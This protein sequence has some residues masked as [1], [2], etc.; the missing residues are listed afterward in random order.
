MKLA[1]GPGDPLYQ[2]GSF[3]ADP[4]VGRLYHRSEE[5]PL[6]P[7]SFSV[8]MVLVRLQGQLVDKEELF[9]QVWPD[10]FVEPNN[11]AR[12]VSMIRKA[13]H[14][15]D[16]DQEYIATVP[17]RGYRLL[18]STCQI[19]RS[20]F[21]D[22]VHPARPDRAF[23]EHALLRPVTWESSD[24][25]IARSTDPTHSGK[26]L[27][28][29]GGRATRRTLS[30]AIS[31]AALVAAA[32]T[33][34]FGSRERPAN[35]MTERRLWQLS[36][37]GR[38]Q[39]DPTW[40]PDGQLIAYSSDRG[41][42]FDIWVQRLS[43]GS[44][45]QMTSG[46][47]RDWQPS[48]SPDGRYIAFRS[49]RDGGSLYV[50]P[51]GGGNE[52]RIADFGYQPQW[53]PDGSR[54][55]F[56]EA[57]D[58]YVVGLDGAAPSRVAEHAL[59]DLIGRF[60]VAWHPDGRR[61][62]VYGNDRNHGWSFWTVPLDG[63]PRARSVVASA[64]AARL[65]D[66]G[67]R[68]GGFIWA[69][70]GDTLYFEGR[71]EQTQNVWRI[72]VNPRTLEWVSGPD[73]LTT[74]SN[75][76]SGLALSPDG[77]QLA[78]GSRVEHTVAWSFPFDPVSGRI[79]G[80][81]E[82]VTPEGANAE[83]LD[84]SPDGNQLV[85][86]VTGRNRHELWIRSLNRQ[87]DFL[88]TVEVEA[89]IVQPRWSRDGTQLAYLRRPADRMH[90][91]SVVLL[92]A[93]DDGEERVLAADHSPE[94]VYDWSVDGTSLLV[95]CRT[96]SVRSAICRMP[97]A[98]SG[99]KPFM[100]LFAADED[101]NLY[102]AKYSPDGRWVSFIAAPDLTRSTVFVSSADGGP[103]IAITEAEDRHFE[104]KPRWS[105]DG[106]ALYF[107]SNRTGFWNVWGRRF[108]PEAARPVGE[109]FQVSRFDSSV[110]MV[111]PNVSNLQIAVTG[112][113]LILPITQTSGNV[114]ILENV[115][116]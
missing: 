60:R 80:P 42:S 32:S 51:A 84:I 31:L 5:V 17:G 37:M 4:V 55:L 65:R 6:T 89:A 72:R 27:P 85:Y 112:T 88:R 56:S 95:R 18:A 87:S 115:D 22:R 92:A 19:S 50:V 47:T 34:V 28:T 45:I 14:E 35:S 70:S 25:G 33:F 46:T 38:Q 109:P 75:L 98:A 103:W 82:A 41:D 108:D 16:C 49:E 53:S 107:L 44:P 69:R 76:E 12:N 102:A 15:R 23:Q 99:S 110:Q 116:Q 66:S 94:M 30:I 90:P 7:K 58:L 40:S 96:S 73:R 26:A 9:R 43:G 114:W 105:P 106:R 93:N 57:Q 52:R 71:S 86:N 113:R 97:S 36:S 8:L 111:H 83:I 59:S 3:I 78:F 63:G 1:A 68:L 2:F 91:A 64:V 79:T 39:G 74:S 13:L 54:I 77:K 21:V 29:P 67:L 10:T 61:I 101:F 62:S 100:R 20:E 104:D 24:A 81:G 48:W 11:L